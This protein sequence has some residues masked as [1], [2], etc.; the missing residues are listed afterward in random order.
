MQILSVNENLNLTRCRI[1]SLGICFPMCLYLQGFQGTLKN[2]RA[3]YVAHL[4]I[5]LCHSDKSQRL[6]PHQSSSSQ[7]KALLPFQTPKT[8]NKKKQGN[9]EEEL[10]VLSWFCYDL[11]FVLC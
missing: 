6:Y 1:S 11:V 7:I 9:I 5:Q 2:T 3:N 4:H 10:S 8:I